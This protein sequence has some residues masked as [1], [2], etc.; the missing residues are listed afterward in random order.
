MYYRKGCF[1]EVPSG[2]VKVSH[3]RMI[4]EGSG[5]DFMFLGLPHRVSGSATV[6]GPLD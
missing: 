4:S 5:K 3:I 1:K 2:S 6:T